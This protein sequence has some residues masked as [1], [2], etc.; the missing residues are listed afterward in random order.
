[1]LLLL[2]AGMMLATPQDAHAQ[3]VSVNLTEPAGT[4]TT[5]TFDVS[6]S[7]S[8]NL[9]VNDFTAGDVTVTTTNTQGS[10][11]ATV[12]VGGTGKNWK[13]TV[14]PPSNAVG[15]VVLTVKKESISA[16]DSSHGLIKGPFSAQTTNSISFDT[17]N[18]LRVNFTEPTGVQ[19][20]STFTVPIAFSHTVTGFT[21]ADIT[22]ATTR[23]SGSGDAT[24]SLSGSGSSYTATVTPPT[25]ATGSVTLTVKKDSVTFNTNVKGPSSAETSKSISFDTSPPPT[26]TF[27][28]PAGEQI[29]NT[30]TVPI[31]I[32]KSVTGFTAS[33]ITVTTT[34]TSGTGNA[35]VSLSGSGTSYTATVTSPTAAKGTI[36]LEVAAD[37]V[38][39]GSNRTGPTSAT[40]SSAINFDTTV[41]TV[42]FTE[43]AGTQ[44][45]NTFTV[46]ITISKSV[47][48]FAASDITV[49]TT[50]T[51]GTGNATVALSGSGTSYT[52]T[53]T[54][55]TAAKG[56]I[57]LEVAKDAVTDGTRTGPASAATSSAIVFDTTPPTVTFTE[58]ADTQAG[59]TFDVPI[60]FSKSVTGFA[61]NDITVTTTLTSGTGNATV[62]VTGSGKSWTAT[63]TS[64]TAAKGTITLEVAKGAVTDGTRTGPASAA[65]SD[66]M[67]FDTTPATV[68]F[69]EPTVG[70]ATDFDVPITFSKSVTG[71]AAAD[72]TITTT[73]TSGT[74]DATFTLSGSGKDYTATITVPTSAVGTVTLE[75]AADSVSDGTRTGPSSKTASDAMSFDT[76]PPTVSFSEPA[77]IQ[78]EDAFDVAIDFVKS[79]TGFAA[80]DITIT[81]TLTSG[82]GNA[83]F[84][85]LGSGSD[86][87]VTV[88]P[89]TES[90]GTITL[91]VAK[92]AVTDSV[93]RVG[94]VSATTS[95]SISFDNTTPSVTY[96]V[97]QGVQV[98]NFD[99]PI[100]FSKFILEFELN[101][102]TLT[103][104]RTS[105]TGDATF[106][107]PGVGGVVGSS[108]T[109][110]TAKITLPAN[111]AGTV[112]LS[113][114]ADAVEDT[115]EHKG[116]ASAAATGNISFDTR[117]PTVSFTEPAGTQIADTFTVPITINKSVTGLAASD[118]TVTSST[119]TASV[120]L[121]GSGSS[122]T[123]TVTSP[124]AAKG[125][126]TLE[127]A[128]DA[129]T[130][131]TR[132]GPAS[133][134]TSSAISF[135]TTVPTVTFTEPAGT[136]IADTFDVP[137][138]I[139]KSVTGFAA[140]DITV[141]S[142]TGTA[143]VALSGSG[144]SY[145]ATV[146][147]P[148]AAKGTITL[149]VAKDAVTD[150]TRTGPASKATSSAI[151]FDTTVPTVTFTEPAGTQY[152]NTFTVPITFSKSV[153]GFTT[154]PD[155]TGTADLTVKTT[156][157][158]G[159]GNATVSLSGSGAS[160]TATISL[161]S[162][163]K[164]TVTLEVAKNAVTDG[165]RTGPAS[166]ATSSAISFDTTV[167]TVDFTE[168]AGTQYG[169]TFTVPITFSKS[170]TG[171]AASDI[172]VTSSTGTASVSLSG[173]GTSYTATVTSPTAAKGTITLAVAKDAV[174]DGTRTG[175]A[176]K[177]T[178]SAIN[179]DTTVTTV[180]FTEPAGTQYGDTFDV[181][182]TFSKGITGFAASDITVT[183]STGT[184]SVS[185][186]GSGA[187]YTA[188]VTSPTAAK[189]TIT[190]EVAKDAVT[191]GTRTG[192]ASK[193]TSSAINFDTTVAT[194]SFTEPAKGTTIE[195]PQTAST[196]DVGIT[197]SKSVTG[198]EA[199][200]ITLQT[201]TLDSGEASF[202]LSGSGSTYTATI[203][204]PST[205]FTGGV[206]LEVDKNVATDG[207][208]TA[209]ASKTKS[210]PIYFDV[211]VAT[212]SFDEPDGVQTSNNFDVGIDFSK[213]VTGFTASDIT[214]TTT[215][216]SGSGTP[217]VS[218][219]GS[220]SAYTATITS[221]T[222][223]KGTIV[224]EVA[225]D[226]VTD[227]TRT[228]PDSKAVSAAIAFDTTAPTVTFSEPKGTQTADTF[229]VGIN[230]SKSVTGFE[231]SD[232]TITTTRT[233][234]TG[235][236]SFTLS[237]SGDTYTAT[238]TSPTEAKGTV[239][240]EIAKNAA[241]DGTKQV[242][243]N[244]Q[245]SKNIAF[246]TTTPQVTYDE[247]QGTQTANTFDVGILFSKSVTGFE[248]GDIRLATK[249]AAGTDGTGN[250][251]LTLKGSGQSWTARISLPRLSKGTV[252]LTIAANAATD[253][254]RTGPANELIGSAIA[255]DTTVATV[256]FSE[257]SG[258]QTGV[259]FEVPITFSK[260]VTGFNTTKGSDNLTGVVPDL[261]MTIVGSSGDATI[262]LRGSGAAYIAT[263]IPPKAAKG[264]LTLQV[265]RGAATD[266]ARPAPASNTT[267]RAIAFDTT[268][269]ALSFSEPS[270]T[271]VANTFNVG[272][273]FSKSVT[274]FEAGDITIKTTHT[275]GSGNATFTLSGS[276]TSYTATVTSPTAAK[277]TVTLAVGKETA[278][279]GVNSVP[280]ATETS[281]AIA[282][283]TTTPTV[284]FTAPEGVSGVNTFDIGI[285]FSKDVTGFEAS[286]IT[287]TTTHTEGSGD[288]TFT[289]SGSDSDYT[290]A[291]AVPSNAAGTIT[292]EVAANA[293]TDGHRTGPAT[294]QSTNAISFRTIGP[295]ISQPVISDPTNTPPQDTP[296]VDTTPNNT[297]DPDFSRFGEIIFNEI[298]NATADENDWIELKNTWKESI[299]IEG[300][301]ISIVTG[302]GKT[303]QE[304][305]F[306]TLP[307][308]VLD[309]GRRLLIV[310]TPPSETA[311]APGIN[312]RTTIA[313]VDVTI[314]IAGD[315]A[316]Y[317][318]DEMAK[319]PADDYFLIL[320]DKPYET[321][322]VDKIIDIAGTYWPSDPA[323]DSVM[324]P[325]PIAK[326]AGVAPALTL[327]TAWR[328]V[329]PDTIGYLASAWTASGY[330]GGLGYDTDAP[331]ALSLGSPGFP[332]LNPVGENLPSGPVAI[333][334]IMYA[335]RN[336]HH[337]LPQWIELYNT[338]K[339]RVDLRGWELALEVHAAANPPVNRMTT[340]TFEGVHVLPKQTLLLVTHTG[341]KSSDFPAHKVYDFSTQK[342][343]ITGSALE[344]GQLGGQAYLLSSAGFCLT[345]TD[346]NGDVIDKVGNLDGDPETMDSP[347]WV[348]SSAQTVEGYRSSL[349]RRYKD[350]SA[351]PGTAVSGW[352]AA[353]DLPLS[354]KTYWGH[355]TDIGNPGYRKGGYLPV[356]LSQF[357][358]VR[359]EAA[360]V[361]S[362]TTESELNNAGFNIYRSATRT[363]KFTQVNALLISG[364]GTTAERRAYQ[365][366]D[367]TARPNVAYYYRIEDVSFNGVRE[368][369]RTV[370]LRGHVSAAGK[371]L[372]PWASVKVAE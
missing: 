62:T 335:Q 105:G 301:E 368:P 147:S 287:L 169:N 219:S 218:L 281:Q 125:T 275:S 33:D 163:A 100:K 122:Y 103:T 51:S 65:T 108:G 82:T 130:D 31:T 229:T 300:W 8:H 192:P 278:N 362:W 27:T 32:S 44:V 326:P 150:G 154:T 248:V 224:L 289:L 280:A 76:N 11:N 132:T 144:T 24:V 135:D 202:T 205:V 371:R 124:T 174:T 96:T 48:G 304:T 309:P 279:D 3:Y 355:A 313:D 290:A 243:K 223:A 188:T 325:L 266:G 364:S 184:A 137:I 35:T 194:V 321:E 231:A 339:E 142:S 162:T 254:T 238:V 308:Y 75:V 37:S 191:D 274:G 164:G 212:V 217:S 331:E 263:V 12:S 61:A 107:V 273:T 180:S 72:I 361:L 207:T 350:G 306:L 247:P 296:P 196:F 117:V 225:K 63:V 93:S 95:E 56:T 206:R 236:A 298:Y 139:S 39:D 10:G 348:L 91:E 235:N 199:D 13:I 360:V 49:T 210:D 176:S 359:T 344:N 83:T 133:K 148:T 40:T 261:K 43:P 342:K 346:A 77:G 186:S 114:K 157:T 245:A 250:A 143:S 113:M 336:A 45:A 293:A 6:V 343:N 320:R 60:T 92:N 315:I 110:F 351:L 94:P 270:G 38:T 286:D 283:D 291:I 190:L 153:T 239:K 99:V 141:T 215:L 340:I 79:V 70:Q 171:F 312:V 22:V 294:A 149:E 68:D 203:T 195:D 314:P 64:P 242:P 131:G 328:R 251:E 155:F 7:V 334:E 53:V 90:K 241:S 183:S 69:T 366:K 101:D 57:T 333:S 372:G 252:R 249:H 175:P 168:P 234:G 305:V 354:F 233:N 204:I 102:L 292:L 81:T 302:D 97:P 111:A 211:S 41:A 187:S 17:T 89:P 87:S 86:Y 42:D 295:V 181:P 193:G 156:R 299:N 284:S 272:I 222:T 182:I 106:R 228:A 145:T 88:T 160:Y 356:S 341:R 285:T 246:D 115:G 128:K 260:S 268:G 216:T 232:L 123:A 173:S 347:A 353:T 369:L 307:K 197:F 276:G 317:F 80:S 36:T 138:T 78:Y 323:S 50:R 327:D 14:T 177:A 84:T 1:M 16:F 322:T 237:G 221:L 34:R 329:E 29:A 213:S 59:N 66:A 25:N 365:W 255:F 209:P 134:A 178:S 310:N 200:D 4:Q 20:S 303:V 67:S 262:K 159:T 318:T 357:R 119:G 256:S 330:Q 9:G 52:A 332:N 161:P 28:E 116:P 85:L 259:G 311:I 338:S 337:P 230:F 271:Q 127:V 264:T 201:H 165:T 244:K 2:T 158:S 345:L 170:V 226:A 240:L 151:S 129:V 112:N 23:T 172:T 146:T 152:G 324:W 316:S 21:A 74:G 167:A 277:G 267:S 227:G 54:S 118:I 58:P 319:L 269:A 55:P 30:F 352:R 98:T 220:G 297:D 71:F 136:Q 121:S 109:D 46:P 214:L 189:G 126:I 257:P 282:F 288:A 265:V 15:S 73:R 5:N 140:S 179:F 208:R 120:A 370:R 18:L 363:G 349:I 367:T 253:G 26:V 104:T 358:A 47:T 166:K 19:T 258:V 198:F 185:L